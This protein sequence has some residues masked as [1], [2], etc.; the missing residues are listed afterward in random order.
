MCPLQAPFFQGFYFATAICSTNEANKAGS[1]R[2]SA[3]YITQIMS[4]GLHYKY[5]MIVSD[6]DEAVLTQWKKIALNQ[7]F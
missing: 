4:M 1:M 5:N 3:V 2:H 6:D 7:G